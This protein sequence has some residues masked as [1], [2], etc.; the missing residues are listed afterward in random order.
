[1]S[2]R[3]PI[4]VLSDLTNRSDYAVAFG[5][6]LAHLLSAELYVVHAMD[7]KY[8]PLRIVI[9]AL[10][11][12]D[13]AQQATADVMQAQLHRAAPQFGGVMCPMVD[14]DDAI[15]AI[16][17]RT[18]QLSPMV[19]VSP[20]LWDWAP[21]AYHPHTLSPTALSRFSCPLLIVRASPR[22]TFNRV[23]VLSHPD[24]LPGETLEA[25][26][27]W[28]FW[29]E[30]INDNAK[31]DPDGPEFYVWSLDGQQPALDDGIDLIVLGAD[32]LM[33]ADLVEE[34]NA[35]LPPLLARSTVPIV[36]IPPRACSVHAG[37]SDPRRLQRVHKSQPADSTKALLN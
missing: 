17:R 27:R 28:A 20:P 7:L 6:A 3:K 22:T 16:E 31:V 32:T 11:N 5:A 1:V 34:V 26:E 36:L 19:V 8:R 25:A 37:A 4:L 15:R 29:L 33:K 2:R 23:V 9:S 21:H 14:L 30:R 10:N 18:A 35:V 13:M 12:L 24:A